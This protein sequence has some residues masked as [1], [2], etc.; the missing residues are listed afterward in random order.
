MRP[1]AVGW[2]GVILLRW[3]PHIF[4]RLWKSSDLNWRPWSV[5]IVC[6]HPNIAIQPESRARD[7]VSAVMSG[8][9]KAS[10]QCMKR[11]TTVRQY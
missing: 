2:W 8:M 4:T 7:T 10:G 6:G 11:S 3:M 1:M 9:G 5:M